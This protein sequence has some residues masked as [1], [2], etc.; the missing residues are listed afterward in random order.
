MKRL[1]IAL[2]L[3][4][5][6]IVT[7]SLIYSQAPTRTTSE[8]TLLRVWSAPT[9]TIEERAQAVNHCFPRGTPLSSIIAQLG[10]NHTPFRLLAIF[11]TATSTHGLFTASYPFA[12]EESVRIQVSAPLNADPLSGAFDRAEGLIRGA[13]RPKDPNH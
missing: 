12:G 8:R 5:I 2:S 1:L 7:G 9:S 6:A 11:P 3:L 13:P 4:A 10:T